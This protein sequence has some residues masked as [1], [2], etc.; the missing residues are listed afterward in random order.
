MTKV[1]VLQVDTQPDNLDEL[2]R[3]LAVGHTVDEVNGWEMPM[4]AEPGDLVVW[5]AAG[6]SE[7]VA[8]GWV[9]ARPHPG[10]RN[11]HL[12]YLG[13]VAGV[14]RIKAVHRLTVK[15]A[16]GVDGGHQGYQTA[17]DEIAGDFLRALKFPS[18]FVSAL[19]LISAEVVAV[20]PR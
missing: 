2:E 1:H 3:S 16:C 7:F 20:L 19:E 10:T 5:Y 11:G 12:S 6:R 9:E 13:P 8:R 15:D 17:R 4:K 14:Q 18:R